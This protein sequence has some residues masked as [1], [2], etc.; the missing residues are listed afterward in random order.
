MNILAISG[1]SRATSSNVKLIK[2]L[3]PLTDH[4][5]LL[6][7]DLEYL[8]VFSASQDKYPWAEQV[9]KW[10][11]A[12]RDADALIISTP[13]YIYNLPAAIK[14]ALEW[15]TSSGELDSKPTLA[16]TYT[17]NEPRGEKSMKSLL[18]CLDALNARVVASMSL[19]QSDLKVINGKC[20]A[21]NETIEMIR[22]ALCLLRQ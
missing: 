2:A 13:E 17:P 4:N 9:T 16:I 7:D 20:E 15:L 21:D 6:Y 11:K 10:R 1:S 19:Y 5:I 12:V 14:S 22:E 18:W 3:K 8:P